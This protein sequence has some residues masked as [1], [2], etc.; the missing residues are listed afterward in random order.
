MSD[1]R[2]VTQWLDAITAELHEAAERPRREAELLLM[3]HLGRDQIW[4]ITNQDAEVDN[5]KRLSS[6]SSAVKRM[7]RWSTLPTGSVS[8]RRLFISNPG[9]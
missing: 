9:R 5:P 4:L 8:I 2:T 1:R 7:N 6:G 3:E